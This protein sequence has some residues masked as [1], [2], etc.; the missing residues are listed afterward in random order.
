MSSLI[1]GSFINLNQKKYVFNPN[2]VERK[3]KII[4]SQNDPAKE[5]QNSREFD[6][7]GFSAGLFAPEVLVDDYNVNEEILEKIPADIINEALEEAEQIKKEALE[8]VERQKLQI[9]EETRNQGYNEGIM[10]AQAEL[11]EQ[12][13]KINSQMEE[14][15]RYYRNEYERNLS[16]LPEKCSEVIG[17]LVK[18][19]IGVSVSEY[20]EVI[21]NLV[22]NAL[23]DIENSKKFLIMV[24][25]EDYPFLIQN[26]DKI[27]GALNPS[28]TMEIFTEPRF[29]KSQCT[30]ETDFGIINCSLDT[31]LENLLFSLKALSD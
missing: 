18:K 24:S 9:L 20:D 4:T 11:Q 2:E 31:Q 16:E 30:I 29:T 13:D 28:I 22:N 12:I 27:F 23:R 14:T 19:L 8:E 6:E 15:E 25:E 10:K 26:K 21:L 3:N 5:F 1:K 17:N 7:D